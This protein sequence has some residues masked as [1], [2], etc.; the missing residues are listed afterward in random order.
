M[1]CGAIKA[2]TVTPDGKRLVA[3]SHS[4]MAVYDLVA[5]QRYKYDMQ[6]RVNCGQFGARNGGKYQSSLQASK[7]SIWA[8]WGSKWGQISSYLPPPPFKAP[9]VPQGAIIPRL[10]PPPLFRVRHSHAL[11]S[12]AVHP[13]GT[14]VATG[15]VTGRITL[16]YELDSALSKAA[17]AGTDELVGGGY[18]SR[19]GPSFY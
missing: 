17:A 1:S 18:V 7:E 11:T 13:L 16:W 14:C 5:N 6:Y 10:Y 9:S 8:I 12:A 15:D 4:T 3:V 2:L 19:Q